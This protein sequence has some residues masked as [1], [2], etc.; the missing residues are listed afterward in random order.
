MLLA[1][2][3]PI[4]MAGREATSLALRRRLLKH[5]FPPYTKDEMIS[6]LK[7]TFPELPENIIEQEVRSHLFAVNYAKV[8]HKEPIPVF[9][10]LHSLVKKSHEAY[11]RQTPVSDKRDQEKITNANY[12]DEIKT[13]P[14]SFVL[15]N[16]LQTE[17]PVNQVQRLLDPLAGTEEISADK[18]GQTEKTNRN[19]LDESKKRPMPFV[20]SNNLQVE[21]AELAK[22]A[23]RERI[24]SKNAERQLQ[25]SQMREAQD[26]VEVA[27]KQYEEAK[28]ATQ[29]AIYAEKQGYNNREKE[30]FTAA[31][32]GGG[33]SR[34]RELQI[35]ADKKAEMQ[36]VVDAQA[37]EKD[38]LANLTNA[39]MRATE[40]RIDQKSV[41]RN[42]KYNHEPKTQLNKPKNNPFKGS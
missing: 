42:E 33:I 22:Q 28:Q 40:V 26:A 30:L 6:I 9:R 15:S 23:E 36:A 17:I 20:Y 29:A 25:E 2:Q 12:I 1:T 39:N 14:V 3:N 7:A 34:T 5:D 18:R 27:K 24:K 32:R 10:D 16:T 8:H 13:H 35:M 21:I 38:A 19:D 41:Q 37:K 31:L 11:L 4:S